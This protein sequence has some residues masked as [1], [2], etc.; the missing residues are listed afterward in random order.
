M[1]AALQYARIDETCRIFGRRHVSIG[2]GSRVD[3]FSVITAGPGDVRI[4]DRVHVGAGV[5]IFGTAGVT[6]EEFANISG[7]A[8]IYST[9]DD[10]T[11]GWIAGPLVPPE[12]RNVTEAPVTVRS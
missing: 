2:R 8:S 3:A 1:S 6:V 11:G 7:R 12:F 4:G 10:F 9:S 5:Q